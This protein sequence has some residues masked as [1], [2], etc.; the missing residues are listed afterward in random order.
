ML[1]GYTRLRDRKLAEK[2]VALVIYP[3]LPES[4]DLDHCRCIFCQRHG[5]PDMQ[6]EIR[7]KAKR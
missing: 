1:D 5:V 3:P 2:A 6:R 4:G 7:R